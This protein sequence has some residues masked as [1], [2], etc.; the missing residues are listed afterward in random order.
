MT[1][2]IEALDNQEVAVIDLPGAFLHAE[3]DDH[4]LMSFQGRLAELMVMAAPE[5][6]RK[7]VTT[8]PKGEP[9]LFVRLQKAL[10]LSLK[11]WDHKRACF[12]H[13]L[14]SNGSGMVSMGLH[15]TAG[16][17]G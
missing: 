1:C 14:T 4:V 2:T 13:S 3:C 11:N 7:Y 5:T 17:W 6:Y 16:G 8:G 10:R 12:Q 9:M 15:D